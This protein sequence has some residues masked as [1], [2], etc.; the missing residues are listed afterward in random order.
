MAYI[1]LNYDM[2]LEGDRRPDNQWIAHA[3]VPDVKAHLFFRKRRG[4]GN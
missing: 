3:C 2:R 4:H 1:L